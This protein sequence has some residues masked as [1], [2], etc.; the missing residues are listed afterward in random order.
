MSK[1]SSR[2]YGS[3]KF[4]FLKCLSAK[5]GREPEKAIAAD[6]MMLPRGMF[7]IYDSPTYIYIGKQLPQDW[8]IRNNIAN[9]CR[10][11]T[12]KYLHQFPHQCIRSTY[13]WIHSHHLPLHFIISWLVH[14]RAFSKCPLLYWFLANNGIEH[15]WWLLSCS[16]GC[17]S[18]I[19][20]DLALDTNISGWH[21]MS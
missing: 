19:T 5:V 16:A 7:L 3:T 14:W 11:T 20:Q 17:W 6:N 12:L 2:G 21:F 8:W 9:I 10:T 13:V 15:S 1:V 18:D 4:M